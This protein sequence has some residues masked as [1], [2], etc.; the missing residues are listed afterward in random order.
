M[1][2]SRAGAMSAPTIT[3]LDCGW[4]RT[5]QRTLLHGGTTDLIDI[6]IPAWLVRHGDDV[7]VFDAGLH[8]ALAE[9]AESLGRMSKLFEP[10]L[11]PGGTVAPRLQEHDVDPE[12]S[13]T[14][15]ISHTHFDHVGGLCELPNAR[16]VVD[17]DEWTF[18]M[19]AGQQGGFDRAL[20]DLGHDVVTVKGEH[21]LFDDGTVVCIPTPGHTCGHQ[22]L[23][24]V[25]ADG[26]VILTADAC[27]FM[28]TLDDEVLP[29]FGFDHEQQ[30]ESLAMLRRERD[31]GTKI[32]PGHDP[33]VFR[34]LIA[35][36]PSR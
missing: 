34:A 18:A 2:P 19:Q 14:V 21:D 27:Y 8:P 13:L 10:V 28:H 12:A 36:E 9:S 35:V 5:Q 33:D 15:V 29:P 7:V 20:I 26:P 22:S 17:T 25:T 11:A 32:V 6:P 4:L 30:R 1:V 24:V 16:V 31:G 23:R 3:A